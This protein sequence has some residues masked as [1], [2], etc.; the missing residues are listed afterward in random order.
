MFE[1]PSKILRIW[2]THGDGSRSR[3]LETTSET[4]LSGS[5][6][7]GGGREELVKTH[8]GFELKLEIGAEFD[9]FG[10]D[11]PFS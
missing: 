2:V 7:S 6:H 8:L 11:P 3:E 10:K 4:S 5:T 1:D 9:A